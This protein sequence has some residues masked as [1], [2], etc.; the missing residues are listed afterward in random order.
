MTDLKLKEWENTNDDHRRFTKS[1][2]SCPQ[3]GQLALEDHWPPSYG[4][5]SSGGLF[6][7]SSGFQR[8]VCVSCRVAFIVSYNI[9]TKQIDNGTFLGGIKTEETIKVSNIVSLIEKDGYLLT[10]H[11][12]WREKVKEETGEYPREVYA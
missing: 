11:D 2:Q 10:P 3:C 7:E 8:F 4:G 1:H 9:K 6:S 12:V 5:G